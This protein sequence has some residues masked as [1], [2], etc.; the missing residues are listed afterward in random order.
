MQAKVKEWGKGMILYHGSNVM[1]EIPKIINTNRGLD[2]GT[3][4]YTT[5][6]Y[7]QAKQW[8]V[9]KAKRKNMGIP[10]VSVYD[11]DESLFNS[12]LLCKIFEKANADW[13]EYVAAN[14]TGAYK[15]I[16]YDVL[17]G[18]VA[19]DRT[20]LVINDYISGAYS[21]ETAIMLLE[22]AKLKD[23]YAFLTFKAIKEL[24]FKEAKK[25]VG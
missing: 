16:Q 17:V 4:F 9:L 25:N 21:F 1:V 11:F 13:L 7:E 19:N 22:S 20:I 8:A 18:P 2:F 15:G 3:G 23:Q 14:R 6:D 5:T 12:S 10:T 24:E